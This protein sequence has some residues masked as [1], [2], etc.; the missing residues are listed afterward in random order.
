MSERYYLG[1]V[2]DSDGNDCTV[3]TVLVAATTSADACDQVFTWIGE[4]WPEDE[5][6]GSSGTFH[7]CD[8]ECEH[9]KSIGECIAEP[10]CCDNWD[11]SHGGVI[12]PEEPDMLEAYD[13]EDEARTAMPF[14]HVRVDLT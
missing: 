7:P 11:C 10:P 12:G 6:D 13:T 9:G 3:Y 1:E 5:D 2:R 4:T 14:Y 8:C